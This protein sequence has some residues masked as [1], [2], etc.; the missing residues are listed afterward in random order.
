MLFRSLKGSRYGELTRNQW[1]DH[2]ERVGDLNFVYVFEAE[3]SEVLKRFSREDQ[4]RIATWQV[5]LP[6]VIAC[7]YV[8]LH[9]VKFHHKLEKSQPAF[10]SLGTSANCGAI[11]LQQSPS[12]SR[13]H[14]YRV[15]W[16]GEAKPGTY[17]IT[18]HL[19]RQD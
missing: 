1:N 12:Y 6:K 10:V 13:D 16:N 4:N 18:F 14:F 2:V 17:G 19:P 11:I 8:G 5:N 7:N 15:A 9:P 3:Q